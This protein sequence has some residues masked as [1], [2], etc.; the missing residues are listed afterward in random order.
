MTLT[1]FPLSLLLLGLLL[2][3][4][5][6]R[7]DVTPELNTT[8][9]SLPLLDA[10]KHL[11]M[12]VGFNTENPEAT[13]DSINARWQ[14][15]LNKGM[16]TGRVQIDWPELEPEEGRYDT[17]ALEEALRVLHDDGLNTALLISVYDSEGP[18]VPEYLEG[19]SLNDDRLLDRFAALMNL[20]I[21]MLVRY[22]GWVIAISNEPDVEFED[23]RNLDEE[24]LAFLERTRD[25]I[26]LLEENMA[27]TI[28]M[29]EGSLAQ[30]PRET[31]AIAAACDV[32]SINYYGTQPG[33]GE[34]YSVTNLEQ[35]LTD[36][37][38]F[39]GEKSI[40]FQELGM[41]SGGDLTTSTPE[42][43]QQFF[44]AFFERM[45]REERFRAAW[46]FQL[47]DW[48]PATTNLL[49]DLLRAE[50]VSEEFINEYAE[51]LNTL[52]VISFETGERKPAWSVITEWM[53]K[54][55]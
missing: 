36:L 25:H 22:D 38:E 1:R 9:S 12:I 30:F 8:A 31:R 28:T 49:L 41:H 3:S 23:F 17:E 32:V 14:E 19:A 51:I 7:R 27:V 16:K 18:V 47:V 42:I 43:Q 50:N 48:S 10:G 4:C 13:T 35:E 24:V 29:N 33:E 40:I 44:D 39:A 46:V 54:F 55:E 26:H 6:S 37:L 5:L 15:A 11:G 52:G 45:G 20:V 21:P 34:A 2:T 53:Q